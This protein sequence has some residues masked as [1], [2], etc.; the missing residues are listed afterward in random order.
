MRVKV[1]TFALIAA[2]NFARG[3]YGPIQ[4]HPDMPFS[5]DQIMTQ[6]Q[7]KPDGTH[8]TLPEQTSKLY[9]DSM[10]RTRLDMYY[11]PV[12]SAQPV[13]MNITIFD[14]IEGARYL[15]NPKKKVAQKYPLPKQSEMP[16][17]PDLAEL[18]AMMPPGGPPA[19]VDEGNSPP[20]NNESLGTKFMEGV[21]ARGRRT[22]MRLRAGT[23]GN[24]LEFVTV[25]EAWESP[26]LGMMMIQ[27][28]NFDSRS[29]ELNTRMTNISR[30]E[31]DPSL[32]VV[33]A[34]YKIEDAPPPGS[35]PRTTAPAH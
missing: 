22:T 29:G 35:R 4:P 17:P 13:L 8:V 20:S 30:K 26:E 10:G 21:T 3:Q 15:L 6:V 12:S 28:K 24:E 1:V 23:P 27:T 34:D 2:A 7:F 16:K 18:L 31:P 33:P 14:S 11:P 25:F 9:R 5:A 32:F 19:A